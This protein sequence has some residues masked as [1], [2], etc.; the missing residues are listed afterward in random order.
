MCTRSKMCFTPVG[1]GQNN[2]KAQPELC[3]S[4]TAQVYCSG[5]KGSTSRMQRVKLC[6]ASGAE[7]RTSTNLPLRKLQRKVNSRKI[8]G[9][10]PFYP[11]ILFFLS[12]HAVAVMQVTEIMGFR[13]L[14]HLPSSLPRRQSHMLPPPSHTLSCCK[15]AVFKT[16]K[17]K[18]NNIF[19]AFYLHELY[20]SY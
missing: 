16:L 7:T 11:D 3:S 10:F 5:L 19:V 13:S 8:L 17:M 9:L 15:L 1:G 18:R 14:G 20:S 12:Q 6:L 4:D 2:Q